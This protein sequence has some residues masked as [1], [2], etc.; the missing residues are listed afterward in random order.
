M[1]RAKSAGRIVCS[2]NPRREPL[3]R[4]PSKS[5]LLL[6]RHLVREACGF[7]PLAFLDAWTIGREWPLE[8]QVAFDA[9]R[10][11][12][13]H[14]GLSVRCTCAGGRL[15]SSAAHD[16]DSKSRLPL[17]EIPRAGHV[18]VTLRRPDRG[19]R[20][21]A[22]SDEDHGCE[23]I[24]HGECGDGL[25]SAGLIRESI[26]F[27]CPSASKPL[28]HAKVKPN[29]VFPS[30]PPSRPPRSSAFHFANDS[31]PSLGKLRRDS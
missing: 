26:R 16:D 22:A 28:S 13:F 5:P 3:V 23:Q 10:S 9:R 19:N 15:D 4:P 25:E 7:L 18:K 21:S 6:R 14:H 29:T 24:F 8:I 27:G 11:L 17:K 2:E 20:E 31:S 12:D 1:R 30:K